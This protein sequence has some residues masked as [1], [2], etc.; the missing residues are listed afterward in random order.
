MKAY[1]A[2]DEITTRR[3]LELIQKCDSFCLDNVKFEYT[4]ISSD[5]IFSMDKTKSGWVL[6][7]VSMK[8]NTARELD[9][10]KIVEGKLVY[11]YSER[12]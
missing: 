9:E 3:I 12:N 8:V 4:G 6:V 11:Q 1:Y 10:Y 7:V 5:V 2:I